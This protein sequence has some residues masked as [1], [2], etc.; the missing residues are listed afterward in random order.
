MRKHITHIKRQQ[1]HPLWSGSLQAEW[2]TTKNAKRGPVVGGCVNE[3]VGLPF[4]YK[5]AITH[6]TAA[7]DDDEDEDDCGTHRHVCWQQATSQIRRMYIVKCIQITTFVPKILLIP[8][9]SHFKYFSFNFFLFRNFAWK[10]SQY[11]CEK[12]K[13]R[14]CC[15]SVQFAMTDAAAAVAN[16][17]ACRLIC[18]GE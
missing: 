18:R 13:A 5:L 2:T 11:E 1:T 8:C 17:P 9:E 4:A 3:T 14:N 16:L 15:L 10:L 12:M 6:A 7:D